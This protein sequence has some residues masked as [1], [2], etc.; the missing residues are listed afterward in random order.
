MADEIRDLL[1]AEVVRSISRH[2]IA[3]GHRAET[4]FAS[5][6]EEEDSVTGELLGALRHRWSSVF[7]AGS[8]GWRWRV[9]TRKFRG[10]GELATESLIGADGIIQLEVANPGGQPVRKGILFQAKKGWRYRN[11]ILLTQ[12]LKM[13]A[14]APGA[15]VVF[16]YEPTGYR[17]AIGSAVAK[18]DGRPEQ[19]DLRRLGEFLGEEFLG[20]HVGRF[21]TY[22]DWD[23][24]GMVLAGA[25]PGFIRLYPQFLAAIQAEKIV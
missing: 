14:V 3:S 22:F 21:D 18:S 1:P 6:E 5:N 10:K 24:S 20:C 17:A 23:Q 8:V 2:L 19:A 9:T 16:D 7:Q 13:E 4:G 25:S 12:V 15:S 11:G